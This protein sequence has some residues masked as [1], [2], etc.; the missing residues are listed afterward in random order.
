MEKI[1]AI[2]DEDA[3]YCKRLSLYLRQNTNLP[4][5]IYPLLTEESLESFS[6]K[7]ELDLLLLSEKD[8][9]K[10]HFSPKSRK[11]LYL[12][13]ENLLTKQKKENYIYKYQS[14]DQIMREILVQYG[15][16]EL[17]SEGGQHRAEIFMVYSP[18]GRLGKTEF[19][20]ALA[21]ELGKNR[22]TL[23]VSLEESAFSPKS[24]IQERECLTEALYHFKENHLTP[25]ILRALSYPQDSYSTIHPVRSP[26]D[27]SGLSQRDLSLFL[28][29]I[30]EEGGVDA[31][32]VDTDSS[33]SRYLECFS[34]AKKIFLPVL[35]DGK[36]KAKL[37]VL[38]QYLEKNAGEAVL[39]KFV[40]CSLPPLSEEHSSAHALEQYS[41][42]LL[43]RQIYEEEA[44]EAEQ[45]KKMAL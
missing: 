20:K 15:E 36:S 28:E 44:R 3:L 27:I 14:G 38:Q 26:E 12:S 7:K 42:E 17:L 34:L 10:L 5:Q 2:Y 35:E 45:Y 22:K 11:T 8:A 33:M 29:K 13:E 31:L 24:Q 40:Q 1:L 23:Y 32:V 9:G 41:Q 37:S 30:A 39:E 6:K 19:S 21:K 16:L 25:M 43:L 4:F 18:L